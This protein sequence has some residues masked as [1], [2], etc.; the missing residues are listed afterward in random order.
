MIHETIFTKRSAGIW[1]D[2]AA[3][4]IHYTILDIKLDDICYSGKTDCIVVD[5]PGMGKSCSPSSS[6]S[7]R[8]RFKIVCFFLVS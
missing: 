4:N 5:N 6:S 1:A 8:H 2:I 3:D 7:I